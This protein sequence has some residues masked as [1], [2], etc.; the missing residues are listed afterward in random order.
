MRKVPLSKLTPDMIL[1]KSI[2]HYNNLLLTAGTDH[3]DRF[4]DSLINLGITCVYVHDELSEGIEVP[5]VISD[6][7][8]F[9]CKDALSDVFDRMN[10]EGSFDSI[11]LSEAVNALLEDIL[12]RSDVLVILNDIGTTDD[13]TLVH[14]VNTTILA[15]LLGQEFG[16]S[17]LELK[18]LAEG[19]I[20]HDIGKTMIEPKVLYKSTSLTETEFNLV[21]THAL[22]GYNILKTDPLLTELSRII[23][24]QHHERLDGSGYP[25]N[26]K[27]DEIHPLA[28][29]TAIADMY[30][31]LTSERCYREAMTNYEAYKILMQDAGTKLDA[32]LLEMFF[33]HIALFPNGSIVQL[34]NGSDA[35]VIQQNYG[36]P[37][38]P[39]VRIIDDEQKGSVKSHNL[40]LM[41]ELS[42]TISM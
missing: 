7:T 15:V 41:T 36:V 8:R 25:Y 27:A 40:N 29:I 42:I 35:I 21:K 3:L 20:L 18:N 39:V 14:S 26:L 2:Y 1:A 32:N 17:R 24:L 30:D 38:R 31:A 16:L 4:S 23:A 34:S 12:S 11:A 6:E 37:L 33:K 28:K 5:D 19:T 22:L 13:N 10:R 9:R